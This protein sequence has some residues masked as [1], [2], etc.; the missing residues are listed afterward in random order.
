MNKN[1]KDNLTISQFYYNGSHYNRV[2]D[3]ITGFIK[4][5]PTQKIEVDIYETGHYTVKPFFIIP[6]L[7]N[8]PDMIFITFQL[9]MLEISKNCQ[10]LDFGCGKGLFIY[11]LKKV[12]FKKLAGLET[13]ISRVSFAR[14][15]TGIEISSDFYL[16]GQILNKRYDCVTLIHVLEHIDK[17][18]NF[19][20]KLISGA[21]KK[22]GVVY[23]E[24]PNINSLASKI[25]GN[26][27]AHFTPHFHINHF[28]L[29]SFKNYL[30]IKKLEYKVMGTF[31]FYNSAMGMS[32]ALLSILGYKGSMFEDLKKMKMLIITAFFFLL[33]FSILIELLLSLFTT[34]GSVIKIAIKIK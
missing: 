5:I 10:I 26:T 29:E 17:P 19:L 13:S 11:F 6:F 34:K 9:K 2:E 33:P 18:F 21:V 27:W 8:L 15:L 16:A 14:K 7:I 23:I 22:G 1:S 30:K 24:V 31:S 32:S 4:T 3:E 12:R 20:N 28:T 25:A